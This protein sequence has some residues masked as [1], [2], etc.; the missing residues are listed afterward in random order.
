QINVSRVSI[1]PNQKPTQKK[2]TKQPRTVN[3]KKKPTQ[4]PTQKP[5]VSKP[6]KQP[7]TVTVQ[8]NKPQSKPILR[9]TPQNFQEEIDQLQEAVR[10]DIIPNSNQPIGSK[11]AIALRKELENLIGRV[12]SAH[13]SV[14]ARSGNTKNSPALKRENT[15]ASR[16]T[17]NSNLEETLAQA[18]EVAKNIPVL[19][20]QKNYALARQQ[21]LNAK[22]NLWQQFPIN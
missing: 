6:T 5:N 21:W 22:R 2:P 15:K 16:E 11:D 18:R 19:I 17:T 12:E 3:A 10:L 8:Q 13:L 7:R 4:K 9:V 1:K 14:L 20:S